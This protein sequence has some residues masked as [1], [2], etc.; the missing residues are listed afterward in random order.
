M[1]KINRHSIVALALILLS[2]V[3]WSAQAQ[4][5][6]GTTYTDKLQGSET[7]TATPYFNP[8]T[9]G[10]SYYGATFIGTATGSIPGSFS[11]AVSFEPLGTDPYT[12][13]SIGTI[14][15][16]FSNFGLTSKQG[17]Q[18][19]SLSGTI[20]AGTVEYRLNA[21]G[22]ATVTKI[23]AA[24]LRI[25]NGKGNYRRITRG[26]GTLDGVLDTGFSGTLSLTF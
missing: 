26:C 13:N 5:C 12:G 4:T 1:V 17:K 16:P 7:A 21:N 2:G 8:M 18:S 20:D 22:T 10:I 23:T 24:Q 3:Y 11:V 9:G 14:M 15:T 19:S 25:T 6:S